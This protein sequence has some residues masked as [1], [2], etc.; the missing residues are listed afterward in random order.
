MRGSNCSYLTG[1]ILVFWYL[2]RG[3]RLREVVERGGS[4]VVKVER[5]VQ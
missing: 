2:K 3:G 5:A 4:T 1:K